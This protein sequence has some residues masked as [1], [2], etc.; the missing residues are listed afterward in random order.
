MAKSYVVRDGSGNILAVY[1]SKSKA[2]AFK[3][4]CGYSR[5]RIEVY[6]APDSNKNPS[7][8][9]L[10][11][12]SVDKKRRPEVYEDPADRPMITYDGWKS[13]DFTY[14]LKD[15]CIAKFEEGKDRRTVFCH[16]YG[17]N[18][19]HHLTP[20]VPYYDD[21]TLGDICEFMGIAS[22]AEHI[23]DDYGRAL[24]DGVSY[25][26]VMELVNKGRSK[27]GSRPYEYLHTGWYS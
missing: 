9:A 13:H 18:G 6:E 2:T 22:P 25:E 16:V 26:V 24:I 15:G 3:N 14:L 8:R 21:D 17:P 23:W 1:S 7:R 10:R 19:Y 20:L 12:P 5:A 4:D 11:K 27:R